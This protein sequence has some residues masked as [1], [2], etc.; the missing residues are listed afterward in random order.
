MRHKTKSGH[1]IGEEFPTQI[2]LRRNYSA[3]I[4]KIN[5]STS[6]LTAKQKHT[7][8]L[9][10]DG[11][12]RQEMDSI[13]ESTGPKL[14]ISLRKFVSAKRLRKIDKRNIICALKTKNGK[15]I[16]V[17]GQYE[18]SKKWNKKVVTFAV[19]KGTEDAGARDILRKS[20]GLAFS[21]WGAEIPLKFRRV[22]L[23]QNP[24]ITIRF[25]NDPN[26]DSYLKAQPRVLAYAYYPGTTKQGVIVFNDY[27]YNWEKEDK[28]I[29]GK[30]TWNVNHVGCHE[31]GHS[32]GLSHDTSNPGNDM[33]DPFYN[34]QIYDL[35]DNDIARITK[36]YGKRNYQERSQY[37]RLKRY[38]AYRKRNL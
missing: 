31:I 23:S 37:I 2:Q 6:R 14:A 27:N 18:W 38:L 22:K 16:H 12:T 17:E 10:L 1:Y 5:S 34:G 33:L 28:F 3:L 35:S 7:A 15:L 13:I 25:E 11:I 29:R 32:I 19:L 24:D 20:I 8:I 26:A 30:K 21:T 4:R 9:N 36:K